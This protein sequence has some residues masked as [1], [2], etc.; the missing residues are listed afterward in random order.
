MRYL[1][2]PPLPSTNS[3]PRLKSAGSPP[4]RTPLSA[5]AAIGRC[6]RASPSSSE[7]HA[8][9]LARRHNCVA[10]GH[11]AVVPG[12]SGTQCGRTFSPSRCQL[13]SVFPTNGAGDPNEDGNYE[14]VFDEA[15]GYYVMRRKADAPPR[16]LPPASSQM[17]LREQAWLSKQ[18][19]MPSVSGRPGRD[20][21]AWP[22]RFRQA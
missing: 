15:P 8:V 9:R 5:P 17:T 19:A 16:C 21:H 3:A 13:V 6:G 12:T 22:P 4:A 2:L 20:V 1:P 14:M 10:A 7:K 18:L 11:T